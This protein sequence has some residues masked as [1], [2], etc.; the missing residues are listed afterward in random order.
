MRAQL[1]LHCLALELLVIKRF[2]FHES[3][4]NFYYLKGLLEARRKEKTLNNCFFDK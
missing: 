2:S 4:H 1:A 3:K